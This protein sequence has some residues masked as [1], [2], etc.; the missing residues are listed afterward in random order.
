MPCEIRVHRMAARQASPANVAII[1]SARKAPFLILRS[2]R[3]FIREASARRSSRRS[4]ACAAAITENVIRNRSNP[5]A[6]SDE[7]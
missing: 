7:V 3:R 1:D 4:I 6:I 2:A 5:S